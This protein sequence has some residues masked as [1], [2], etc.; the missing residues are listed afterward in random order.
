MDGQPWESNVATEDAG[1]G[2]PG[3]YTI[4]GTSGTSTITILLYN[5]DEPGTYALGVTSGVVG[6]LAVITS[7]NGS[8]VTP[9]SGAAGTVTISTLSATRIAGTFAF[10]TVPQSGGVTNNRSVTNG[11]F[12][13]LLQSN[14]HFGTLPDNQGSVLSGTVNGAPWNAAAASMVLLGSSL[15]INANNTTYNI[16]VSVTAFTGPGSFTVGTPG[17]AAVSAVVPM[18]GPGPSW[19]FGTGSFTV[20]SL[21]ASRIRG[22]LDATLNP[23]AG[24]GATSPLV[25]QGVVFDIGRQ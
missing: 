3:A 5:I 18:I 19:A 15:V 22:T 24:S 23:S 14:G 8:W 17:Q 9:G 13:L 6:G 21:T 12:D 11:A 1:M 4:Q 16:G 25:I 2:S 7:S 10:T 20:T